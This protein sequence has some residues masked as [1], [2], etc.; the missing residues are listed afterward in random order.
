MD[1]KGID[2]KL[3]REILKFQKKEITEHFIYQKLSRSVKDKHNKKVLHD[4]SEDE[5]SHYRLWK[6]YT[7]EEAEP[8][9]LT[10]WKYYLISLIF[11]ITFGIKLMERGEQ[12]AQASY[13][14]ISRR[15]P[16]AGKIR[17][18]ESEHEKELIKMID[19]ERLR[20][21]GSI[22]LGL[23]D[24]LV[25]LTGALAGFTFAFQSTSL[26]AFAGIITGIAA[27]LSMGASEYLSTKTEAGVEGAKSPVKASV[28]TTVAYVFTVMFLILPFFLFQNAYLALGATLINAI[29]VILIFTFYISVAKDLPFRKRF[30]E[31]ASI[32]IGISAVTFVIGFLIKVFFGISL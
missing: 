13:D 3:K 32:S 31:M 14:D 24:A 18:E 29:V 22:V 23:N 1:A 19:E 17:R 26:I 30:L 12:N 8:S 7:N 5:M 28:Y 16:E 2:E 9:M 25:E 4:I 21:V 10:I 20:Y 6:K 27:S 11:G 15:V